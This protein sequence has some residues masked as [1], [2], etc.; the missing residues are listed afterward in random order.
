MKIFRQLFIPNIPSN[1][2]EF[3]TRKWNI[4]FY[5]SVLLWTLQSQAKT[6]VPGMAAIMPEWEIVRLEDAR[7]PIQI[8]RP[9]EWE[10]LPGAFGLTHLFVTRPK[11]KNR[12]SISLTVTGINNLDF[13][14][15]A[16]E[17]DY[18]QYKEGRLAWATKM[19]ATISQF[20]SYSFAKNNYGNDIHK[21]GVAYL[22]S[23]IQYQEFSYFIICK[24]KKSNLIH[25]KAVSRDSAEAIRPIM[26]EMANNLKC[27]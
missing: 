13:G 16:G 20:G 1:F 18:H 7:G 15:L 26:D 25:L 21:G 10:Y 19:G 14:G 2:S 9:K 23:G 12:T 24:G 3:V 11:V 22:L 6:V 4:F 27:L 8:Q 5:L 17:R